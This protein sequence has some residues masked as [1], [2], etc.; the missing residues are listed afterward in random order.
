MQAIPHMS[1][2][3]RPS[4]SGV[5]LAILLAGWPMVP[6]FAQQADQAAQVVDEAADRTED[7]GEAAREGR[8]PEPR[9]TR[10]EIALPDR[11]LA[12]EAIAGALTLRNNDGDPEADIGFVAYTLDGS[13]AA[14]RPVTFVVNGG[15]GASSAYLHLAAI[16]P[17]LLPMNSERIVPSQSVDLV[18]N[19]E[20]WLDFTD[21]VFI[22]PVGTGFS[23][24]VEP[25]N[26]LRD[27]YLSIDGD[28]EALSRFVVGWLRE[29]GR[30]A[31]P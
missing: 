15:P 23:R 19:P 4:W 20:T 24:L 25:D 8:L 21:L 3:H 10:H 31:S 9:L 12:F 7:Q 16:G 14:S 13:E 29:N 18:A 22:D 6:G 1:L 27:R 2:F 26:R 5:F 11:T 28:V 30:I 17:W